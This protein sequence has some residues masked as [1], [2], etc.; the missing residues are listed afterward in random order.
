MHI[1]QSPATAHPFPSL[2]LG[3]VV[4]VTTWTPSG[5]HSKAV[6]SLA[7][8]QQPSQWTSS[9][10]PTNLS[11]T[12]QFQV[13]AIPE[14]LSKQNNVQS[15]VELLEYYTLWFCIPPPPP[16]PTWKDVW[17]VQ[18]DHEKST[19]GR[20]DAKG[21]QKLRKAQV[22]LRRYY[23]ELQCLE[24]VVSGANGHPTLQDANQTLKWLAI[25][26]VTWKKLSALWF[27]CGPSLTARLTQLPCPTL[28]L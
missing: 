3:A 26:P 2:S 1:Y 15:Q 7:Y 24:V 11:F 23:I 4:A 14:F 27:K 17:L 16:F 19:R 25:W 9:I 5:L 28:T 21:S 13:L 18:R 10:E 8:R 12:E 6:E 22:R 20:R